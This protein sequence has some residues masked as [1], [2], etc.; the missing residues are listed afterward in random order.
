LEA[1]SDIT[2]GISC[3]SNRVDEL[4]GKSESQVSQK[5]KLS[6][7]MSFIWAVTRRRYHI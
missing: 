5:E 4:N 7:L 6:P 2:K 3:S 1:I